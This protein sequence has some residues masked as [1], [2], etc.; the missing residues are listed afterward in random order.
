MLTP[1]CKALVIPSPGFG[2]MDPVLHC[3]QE[4]PVL[5]ALPTKHLDGDNNAVIEGESSS[6]TEGTQAQSASTIAGILI[7]TPA[8]P[9]SEPSY[10]GGIASLD[11]TGIVASDISTVGPHQ[12]NSPTSCSEIPAK[13]LKQAKSP[14]Q[15]STLPWKQSSALGPVISTTARPPLLGKI[16]SSIKQPR[17]L[18]P[19]I[20]SPSSESRQQGIILGPLRSPKSPSKAATSKA[21]SQQ[22]APVRGPTSQS[23]PGMLSM[24]QQRL[25][26]AAPLPTSSTPLSTRQSSSDVQCMPEMGDKS[27]LNKLPAAK[28]DQAASDPSLH[29]HGAQ[30]S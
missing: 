13:G 10:T 15:A 29:V 2:P 11:K 17:D 19:L 24:H 26:A 20:V 5:P 14:E 7:G 16:S 12:I 21:A 25:I 22:L 18:R 8:P 6:A 4:H 28:I 23:K 27:S 30:S 9:L 3:P 1:D